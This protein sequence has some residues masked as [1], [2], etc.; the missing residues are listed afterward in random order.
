MAKRGCRATTPK[1][2]IILGQ[3]FLLTRCPHLFTL[4]NI[5]V[6]S[7]L[8]WKPLGHG[9]QANS[10]ALMQRLHQVLLFLLNRLLVNVAMATAWNKL[11]KMGLVATVSSTWWSLQR[12]PGQENSRKFYL[13]EASL[14]ERPRSCMLNC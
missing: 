2:S 6:T 7:R 11:A 14:V 10:C 12:A 9:S 1:M 4:Y 13:L 8:K 3:N 5:R